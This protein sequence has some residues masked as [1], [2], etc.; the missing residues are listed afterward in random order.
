MFC[1]LCYCIYCNKEGRNIDSE[2]M[3]QKEEAD[4]MSLSLHKEDC[5][6]RNCLIPETILKYVHTTGI[7]ARMLGHL[8]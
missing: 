8:N 5:R 6:I 1:P 7:S 4:E 2:T 3:E